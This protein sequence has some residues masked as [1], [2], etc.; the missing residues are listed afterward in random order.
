MSSMENSI[1]REPRRRPDLETGFSPRGPR[2]GIDALGARTPGPALEDRG[3]CAISLLTRLSVS[4]QNQAELSHH[5]FPPH[6]SRIRPRQMFD[7]DR[8]KPIPSRA[9]PEFE[10]IELLIVP[11]SLPSDVQPG[12]AAGIAPD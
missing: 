6:Q 9:R 2:P 1:D 3:L 11:R 5:R 7:R 12:A 8:E 4:R 10:T